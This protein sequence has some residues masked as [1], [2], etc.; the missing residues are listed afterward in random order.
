MKKAN[1]DQRLRDALDKRVSR[2]AAQVME[3][4]RLRQQREYPRSLH[5][6]LKAGLVREA[7]TV[8]RRK[9]KRA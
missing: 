2:L 6:I 4:D 3:W 7:L 9:L 1:D 5:D 8:R